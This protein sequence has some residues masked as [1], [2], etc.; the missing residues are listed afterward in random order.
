MVTNFFMLP[1]REL[2]Q[3]FKEKFIEPSKKLEAKHLE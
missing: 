3:Q 1:K 2:H